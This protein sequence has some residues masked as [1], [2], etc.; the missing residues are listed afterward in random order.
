MVFFISGTVLWGI[1][2][3]PACAAGDSSQS[4]RLRISGFGTLGIVTNDS[5]ELGFLR[6][7]SQDDGVFK[8]E[9]SFT[10]DSILGLQLNAS[11]N[12]KLDAGFQA[13]VKECGEIG[14]DSIKLNLW[15]E[16]LLHRRII[17][18]IR[19]VNGNS[20]LL[21]QF[22][23]NANRMT[24]KLSVYLDTG[25]GSLR[26]NCIYSMRFLNKAKPPKP[27]SKSVAGSGT[28]TNDSLPPL[29]KPM[30]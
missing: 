27:S 30:M 19:Y 11:I 13:V 10:T 21:M 2:V 12:P 3:S 26:A 9:Y 6:D 15:G 7:L 28:L 23:T 16:S 24:P 4:S 8:N 14:V 18:M 20:S 29:S 5:D 17:D 25:K 1:T 22:N